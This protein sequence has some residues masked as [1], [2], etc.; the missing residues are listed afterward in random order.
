VWKESYV[1]PLFKSG[2]KRNISNYHGISILSAIPK[3]FEKLVCDVV[4]PIIRPSIS[5]EQHGFVGGCST[6]TSLMEFSNFVLSE[7]EDG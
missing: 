2:N 5:Y 3:L 6:V 4:T 7:M 1:V